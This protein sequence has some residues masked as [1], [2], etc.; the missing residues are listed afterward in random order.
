MVTDH[1]YTRL[2]PQRGAINICEFEVKLH[3]Q[4][5]F[6]PYIL[7]CSNDK[8]LKCSNT[9][10]KW[11][12]F[13]KCGMIVIKTGDS[14]GFYMPTVASPDFIKHREKRTLGTRVKH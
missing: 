13:I 1:G 5:F 4:R 6:N 8:C 11:P 2:Y 12:D 10:W 3:L 9:V 7:N 14:H